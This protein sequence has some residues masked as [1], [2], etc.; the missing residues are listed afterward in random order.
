MT[1]R[2]SGDGHLVRGVLLAGCFATLS[3]SAHALGDGQLPPLGIT[4][5]LAGLVGWVSAAAA[6][7]TRGP[8]GVLLVLGTAQLITH[9]LLSELSGH[10]GGGPGMVGTHTAA[11][12]L[13]ALLVARAETLLDLAAAATRRL[14]P[15]LWRAPAVPTGRVRRVVIQ[16]PGGH[17]L[18]EVLL[19]RICGTRGPPVFS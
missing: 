18:I 2:V 6:E 9:L 15:T 16:A 17:N 12:V 3:V 14:L 19:R 4:A 7:H 5:L 11:C 13:T 8:H 1:R 10:G